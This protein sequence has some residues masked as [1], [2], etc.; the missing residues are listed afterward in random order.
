MPL[1]D[2]SLAEL[3]KY[4]GRNP[5]PIDFEAYWERALIEMRATDPQWELK[6]AKFSAPNVECYDLFF[7]GVKG[8]R[9]HAKFLKPA[10]IR[11][12]IPGILQFHGY[13]GNS[14]DWQSKLNYVNMGFA[15]AAM[16]ARGQGGLSDDTNPVTGTT[17][18][19]HIV[20]GLS[21]DNP[22]NLMFRQ[23]FLDTAMLARVLISMD[24]IDETRLGALG[25]SQGGAL[26]IAC[27]ALEP[28]IKKA[29][30]TY[31]FLSDYKRTWE[32]DLAKDAYEELQTYFRQFDP[33]HEREDEIFTK[34]GYIDL[35]YLAPR[36]QAEILMGT[37]L[38]DTICPPSTQFAV[39]NKITSKKNVILYPDFTHEDLPGF[40]DEVYQ[41]MSKL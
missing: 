33:C 13:T 22:D 3:K 31:P 8:G 2:M 20:R 25:A 15:V 7:T 26:T 40:A 41:F 18:C 19:G 12:K 28:R 9:I 6:P 21:D 34:L 16:D 37:G 4:T 35:Q 14:G 17:M 1:I 29:A 11:G 36:I 23:I 38:M 32:M 30:P 39:Y 10:Q 5:K 27:A 24:F